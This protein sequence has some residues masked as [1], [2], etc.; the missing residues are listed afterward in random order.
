MGGEDPVW[1]RELL[2]S[3]HNAPDKAQ[4]VRRMFNAIAP[5]YEWINTVFSA[6][7]DAGWRRTAV[8][9]ADVRCDDDV[10]DIA[11][12]TG[13][14]ARSL[15]VAGPRLVVGSDFAH[16]MLLRGANRPG[17]GTHWCE[18]DALNLPFASGSFSIT[19]CAFGVRNFQDLDTGLREMFRVLRSGGRAVI[20]E[21]T[22]PANRFARA[23]VGLYTARFMP[24]VASLISGDRSGAYRYL[25]KSVVSFADA[26]E[27]CNRLRGVG[28]VRPRATRLTMGLVTVYLAWRD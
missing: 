25:P 26:E 20:L 23:F 22:T 17:F 2:D 13:D 28:F 19:S 4:R 3:P 14:F 18:G 9:L 11:C 7:R 15:A 10:L 16:Q 24:V 1:T 21:F 12:G 5:R 8:G 27:M 6:G